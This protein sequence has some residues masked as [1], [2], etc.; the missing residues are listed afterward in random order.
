MDDDEEQ[1]MKNRKSFFLFVRK[2]DCVQAISSYLGF[3]FEG[4]LVNPLARRRQ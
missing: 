3:C 1:S 2:T 4:K